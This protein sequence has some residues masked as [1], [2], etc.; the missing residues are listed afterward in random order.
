LNPYFYST[1]AVIL[2][3]GVAVWYWAEVDPGQIG[4]VLHN[5]LLNARQAMPEAR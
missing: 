1:G 3:G 5:I 2:V 4:Q